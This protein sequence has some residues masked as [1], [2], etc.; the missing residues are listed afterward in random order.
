MNWNKWT[1]WYI[2]LL[3]KNTKKRIIPIDFRTKYFEYV[4]LS[5]INTQDKKKGKQIWNYLLSCSSLFVS[6]NKCIIL[7]LTYIFF[8]ITQ[9]RYYGKAVKDEMFR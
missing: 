2:G 3:I 7:K 5:G 4:V 8:N 9:L 6:S 1:Q